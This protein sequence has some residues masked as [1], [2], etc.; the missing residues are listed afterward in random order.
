[1]P[2]VQTLFHSVIRIPK[3]ESAFTYF[4][5][6]ANEGLAF[7]S[8]LPFEKGSP[9]RDID[10]KCSVD[11]KVELCYL[12]DRLSQQYPIEFLSQ[13]ELKDS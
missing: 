2:N 7:Y 8:T 12:L 4:I 5:L 6:E 13:T 1:M 9:Y 10:I 3:E 11:F